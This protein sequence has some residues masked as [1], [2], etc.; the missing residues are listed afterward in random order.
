MTP[1]IQRPHPDPV[2]ESLLARVTPFGI[3]AHLPADDRSPDR[4]RLPAVDGSPA[5]EITGVQAQRDAVNAIYADLRKAHAAENDIQLFTQEI[6]EAYEALSL[7]YRLSDA[8][9]DFTNPINFITQSLADLRATGGFRWSSL[10]ILESAAKLPLLKGRTWLDADPTV[11]QAAILDELMHLRDSLTHTNS[12]AIVGTPSATMLR[13]VVVAPLMLEGQRAGFIVSSGQ[14]SETH[15]GRPELTSADTQAALAVSRLVNAVLQSHLLHLEQQATFMGAL[16][17]LT[18]SLEA[19]DRYTRGHSERVSLVAT[20]L[21]RK[22]GY[23]HPDRIE[24]AGRLHDI[25]K[26]GIP[27]RILCKP[28]RLTDEEFE[29]IKTHPVVGHAILQALPSLDDIL[30]AVLH[31]HERWDGRG[32]PHGLEGEQIDLPSRIL[33]LADTFDAMSSNRAYRSGRSRDEVLAEVTRCAG[34]QFDPE[35]TAPFVE[36]DFTLFDDMKQEHEQSDLGT[37]RIDEAA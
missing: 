30:P 34:T 19:K 6:D 24:L 3:T 10:H 18:G 15:L 32:Y 33:A 22:I 29:V 37:Q 4:L 35:L 16:T 5:V 28:S 11:D 14:R 36:L 7:L 2:I 27:D 12:A 1:G 21:A 8:L 23:P 9:S 17:A 26:I 13:E 31:H 25:G 20:Q